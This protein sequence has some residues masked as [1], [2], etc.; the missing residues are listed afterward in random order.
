MA[1]SVLLVIG[2]QP[3]LLD[4]IVAKAA[5]LQQGSKAGEVG[6]VIDKASL[7]KITSYIETSEQCGARIL[8]DGR[9]WTK[10]LTKGFWIGPTVILHNNKED[11]AL[12]DEIFGPVLSIYQCSDKEEAIEI[13]NNNPYGNAA[14]IYTTTGATAEWFI[15]RFSAGMCGVNIGVPVPR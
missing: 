2:S 6:P 8:V 1:A 11:K 10:R 14:C 3:E 5:A 12:H 7:E 15:A 13:E 4:R 9:S